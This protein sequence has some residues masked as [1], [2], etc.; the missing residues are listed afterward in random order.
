M[1][2][3]VI[4]VCDDEESVQ[5]A[6][7]LVLEQDYT[8]LMASDGEEALRQ[9]KQQALPVDLVLLDLK[10]PKRDG[11]EVLQALMAAP[12]PPRVLIL[13]AY[14]SIELAQRAMQMG[15]LDYVTKPFERAALRKAVT[16]ALTLPAWQRP[17]SPGSI[18]PEPPHA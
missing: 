14:H 1:G 2:K 17:D 13:T 12:H 18:A 8:L 6:I 11:V 16:R 15:A 9:V 10:M 7:R 3:P 5:A 4:L